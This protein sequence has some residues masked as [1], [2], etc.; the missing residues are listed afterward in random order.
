MGIYDLLNVGRWEPVFKK[1][2]P[3]GPFLPLPEGVILTQDMCDKFPAVIY[4]AIAKQNNRV[5]MY[6]NQDSPLRLL[7]GNK[8][9]ELK[10]PP[11]PDLE[12]P[13][14]TMARVVHYIIESWFSTIKTLEEKNK[15]KDLVFLLAR[16]YKGPNAGIR[17]KHDGDKTYEVLVRSSP[18]LFNLPTR[19]SWDDCHLTMRVGQRSQ[20]STGTTTLTLS[21]GI[22]LPVPTRYILLTYLNQIVGNQRGIEDID[23]RSFNALMA[24]DFLWLDKNSM[25]EVPVYGMKQPSDSTRFVRESSKGMYL[26]VDMSNDGSFMQGYFPYFN[27]RKITTEMES[28]RD[29]IRLSH[30]KGIPLLPEKNGGIQKSVVNLKKGFNNCLIGIDLERQRILN[31]LADFKKPEKT[32]NRVH[33]SMGGNVAEMEGLEGSN[34]FIKNEDGSITRHYG[35]PL[36][37]FVCLG[38][39]YGGNS[40]VVMVSKDFHIPHRVRKEFSGTIYVDNIPIGSKAEKDIKQRAKLRGS[41]EEGLADY[42]KEKVRNQVM[43]KLRDNPNHEWK[44]EYLLEL[45]DEEEKEESNKNKTSDKDLS[46]LGKKKSMKAFFISGNNRAFRFPNGEIDEELF[47]QAGNRCVHLT[48][49]MYFHG[50]PGEPF[51]LRMLGGKATT[52]PCDFKVF[53]KEGDEL[54]P[55]EKPIKVLQSN[56]C[57]KGPAQWWIVYAQRNGPCYLR[58]NEGLMEVSST[59]E[60]V[61]FLQPNNQINKWLEENVEEVF[62]EYEIS[63]EVMNVLRQEPEFIQELGQTNPNADIEVLKAFETGFR[64]RE[65]I[66]GIHARIPL[67]YVELSTAAEKVNKSTLTAQQLAA[68]GM[69]DSELLQGLVD[70]SSWNRD[71]IEQMISVYVGNVAKGSKWI[72]SGKTEVLLNGVI[73]H[74]CKTLGGDALDEEVSKLSQEEQA[75]QKREI[76]IKKRDILEKALFY[77]EDCL[78]SDTRLMKLFEDVYPSGFVYCHNGITLA[79]CLPVLQIYSRR[80]TISPDVVPIT[81]QVLSLLRKLSRAYLEDK[82]EGLLANKKPTWKHTRDVEKVIELR[83]L[84]SAINGWVRALLGGDNSDSKILAALGRITACAQATV[85]TSHLPSVSNLQVEEGGITYPI[86][87]FYIHPDDDILKVL[88]GDDIPDTRDPNK[89][90]FIACTRTPLGFWMFG[91]LIISKEHGW[92]NHI[93]CSCVVAQQSSETDGDGDMKTVIPITKYVPH[94]TYRDIHTYNCSYLGYL[95]YGFHGKDS[96]LAGFFSAE[97]KWGKQP[98]RSVQHPLIPVGGYDHPDFIGVMSFEE[99]ENFAHYAHLHY[100]INVGTGYSAYSNIVFAASRK[101]EE[102]K[103]MCKKHLPEFS[104][105]DMIEVLSNVDKLENIPLNDIRAKKQLVSKGKTTLCHMA[106]VSLSSRVMYE[107]LG[108]AGFKPKAYSIFSIY[109]A[110]TNNPS[111]KVVP[112]FKEDFSNK[113]HLYLK[114]NDPRLQDEGNIPIFKKDGITPKVKDGIA[115]LTEAL[116]PPEV[117]KVCEREHTSKDLVYDPITKSEMTYIQGTY[118]GLHKEIISIILRSS[119]WSFVYSRMKGGSALVVDEDTKINA[120]CY[121]VMRDFTSGAI[122]ND[123]YSIMEYGVESSMPLYMWSMVN[124]PN[125][126]E[127]VLK[128]VPNPQLRTMVLRALPL[129]ELVYL[130]KQ[131]QILASQA[132]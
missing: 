72:D 3:Q 123:L 114:L 13:T 58:P 37:M 54:V 62:V 40:G 24:E 131:Q 75:A 73:K 98:F 21:G 124:D 86:P 30:Q 19:F 67:G 16:E 80:D 107:G 85:K 92:V 10:L 31:Y 132:M 105:T 36:D 110:L 22:T 65:R 127:D 52:M 71:V 39:G 11:P 118:P 100:K 109:T 7:L 34:I 101:V 81:A 12:T 41:L 120:I 91:R 46:K 69:L 96:T 17:I 23:Y 126:K 102:F 104:N 61:D 83:T 32:F 42:I 130:Y 25:G 64:V 47:V 95:G 128:R 26:C 116:F 15:L 90:Y 35:Y 125:K 103:N 6:M 57:I 66:L 99:W 2:F 88:F 28:S 74:L 51:K 106:A 8:K 29:A 43:P 77:L 55:Y 18:G 121:R 82:K 20:V 87:V 63:H 115:L 119:L 93:T 108:L 38:R 94:L 50:K 70:A 122:G 129:F 49:E 9:V 4:G 5:K 44:N 78:H 14:W 76:S 56:E 89:P 112:Y 45:F 97:S 113:H 84:A 79:V 60:V 1:E 33:T 48:H 59:G 68:L 111:G 117:I 27:L 53:K